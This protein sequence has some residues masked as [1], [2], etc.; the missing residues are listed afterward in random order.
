MTVGYPPL[1]CVSTSDLRLDDT[2]TL[3]IRTDDDVHFWRSTRAY[4]DFGIFLRRLN[5]SVVGYTLPW[6]EPL[7]EATVSMLSLLDT[8]DRWIDEIPPLPTPQRFGN[9]AFRT[10]GKRLES[11]ANAL[12]TALLPS[13]LRS[14]IP[15]L[16]P[17]LVTSFG[18]FIRM[19]YGTGHEASF[20]LLLLCLTLIRFFASEPQSEREIV[21]CVFLRYLRLCWRLQDVYKLEPAG[22]HGVWG[23]DDYSFLGYIFGSGQL[24]DQT[25]IPVSVVLHPPLPPTNLYFMSI[26]RIHEVKH[27]PFHEHSSQLYS[28]AA[29]VASWVKV[30]SGLF[31]MYEAEV[32]GKRVVVQHIPL[33]GLLD[34]NPA[35]M[36]Q[37]TSYPPSTVAQPT[38][39]E[40][41]GPTR[42]PR[43]INAPSPIGSE[44]RP[45]NSVS[46]AS[47]KVPNDP[48]ASPFHD[49]HP[50]HKLRARAAPIV[51]ARLPLGPTASTSL[52]PLSTRSMSPSNELAF[53]SAYRQRSG[54]N[55][56]TSGTG[57]SSDMTP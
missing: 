14:M 38:L 19:D 12:L 40:P 10:W 47:S 29:G 54:P 23:L 28:I 20:A 25:E 30:N 6:S 17:Y 39:A 2:P 13:T 41:G 50:H 26:M 4:Q 35:V 33:G 44:I 42:A 57:T 49:G 5:E 43:S 31:K 11:E 45:D 55:R 52:R 22:S 37:D 46:L 21:L 9:L 36:V 51:P 48:R 8:L 34:W 24:R 16:V 3:K 32:L 56:H 15:F 7:N 27:G 53:D 1:R 18:S